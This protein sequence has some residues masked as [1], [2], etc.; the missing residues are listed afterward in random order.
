METNIG[1][2]SKKVVGIKEATKALKK[3]NVVAVII[4]EDVAQG[5]IEPLIELSR[6]KGVRVEIVPSKLMLGKACNIKTGASAVAL[7]E[8]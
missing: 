3:G 7:L 2:A 6:K 4:A 5:L 1:K 8:D